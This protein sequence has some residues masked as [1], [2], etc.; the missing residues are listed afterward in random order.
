MTAREGEA[1]HIGIWEH[2]HRFGHSCSANCTYLH[3]RG[4]LAVFSLRPIAEAESLTVDLLGWQTDKRSQVLEEKLGL[5]CECPLCSWEWEHEFTRNSGE[6][7]YS[8]YQ[9]QGWGQPGQ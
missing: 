4:A 9:A 3:I 1:E 8:F 7:L 6:L 2:L 5:Q